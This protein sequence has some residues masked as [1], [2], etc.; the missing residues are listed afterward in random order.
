MVKQASDS[1]TIEGSTSQSCRLHELAHR[2][3]QELETGENPCA[4]F[5]SYVS[6]AYQGDESASL[7][8]Q[9][10]LQIFA[11][12]RDALGHYARVVDVAAELQQGSRLLAE[13]VVNVWDQPK[14]EHKLA[15]LTDEILNSP[16]LYASD[17]ARI[18]TVRLAR[19]LSLQRPELATRLMDLLPASSDV[20]AADL[21]T[22]RIWLKAG[23]FIRTQSEAVRYFWVK[24]LRHP[25]NDMDWTRMNVR[26]SLQAVRLAPMDAEVAE[27]LAA[28]VP[29]DVW[30]LATQPVETKPVIKPVEDIPAPV[31]VPR[32]KP[33]TA[34]K[35]SLTPAYMG[36]MKRVNTSGKSTAGKSKTPWAKVAAGVLISSGVAWLTL[37]QGGDAEAPAVAVSS[38]AV[39][40]LYVP[41]FPS[42]ADAEVKPKVVSPAVRVVKPAPSPAVPEKV[43]AQT[44][45]NP[46]S[47]Q[48]PKATNPKPAAMVA[49][50]TKV[51]ASPTTA[52][53]PEVGKPANAI[54]SVQTL[55]LPKNLTFSKPVDSPRTT[56][57]VKP[58]SSAK[59][60]IVAVPS[61]SKS[62][63]SSVANDPPTAPV[64]PAESVA[65]P[66]A[67]N[68]HD[69]WVMMQTRDLASQFP[70]LIEMQQAIVK[71]TWNDATLKLD[72][73]RLVTE[74]RE[75]YAALLRWLVID[76]PLPD[77]TRL[78]V[79]RTWSKVAP[80]DECIGLWEQIVKGNASHVPEIA[81][82]AGEMLASSPVPLTTDHRRRLSAIAVGT[83]AR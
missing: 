67:L 66:A 83:T 9:E 77:K 81:H 6:E 3:R 26:M 15:R 73:T 23:D 39:P 17:E 46:S 14:E 27:F 56:P 58:A 51:A 41:S 68:A 21:N 82:V 40:E 72:G 4:A 10:L 65:K 33:P 54:A 61:T 7:A 80:L 2:L 63:P 13:V 47:P 52:K 20:L 43:V 1:E 64:A 25:S 50:A 36:T 12:D 57:P 74:D 16:D 71:G 32:A 70:E 69:R 31:I 38:K 62:Q 34:P 59:P 49:A 8:S 55:E 78:I 60:S 44:K 19:R 35:S 42:G 22:V 30:E 28:S 37:G 53:K 11:H 45:L 48:T 24:H 18:F 76:P 79:L 75:R 29:D 5:T